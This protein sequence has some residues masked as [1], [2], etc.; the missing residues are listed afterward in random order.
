MALD[1]ILMPLKREL[2]SNQVDRLIPILRGRAEPLIGLAEVMSSAQAEKTINQ[3][4]AGLKGEQDSWRRADLTRPFKALAPRLDD[5]ALLRLAEPMEDYSSDFAGDILN[6]IPQE[7]AYLWLDRVIDKIL[8]T[9]NE[10]R[11]NWM[12]PRVKPLAVR[13]TPERAGK[14][15]EELWKVFIDDQDNSRCAHEAA[16]IEAL[17]PRLTDEMAASL[18]KRVVVVMK[19]PAGFHPLLIRILTPLLGRC[20]AGTVQEAAAGVMA[21]FEKAPGYHA[22]AGLMQRDFLLGLHLTPDQMLRVITPLITE[23][24]N[25]EAP[26]PDIYNGPV[27]CLARMT[28]QLTPDQVERVGNRL[29]FFYTQRP[30][31]LLG[32][33]ALN[34]LATNLPLSPSQAQRLVD[35]VLPEVLRGHTPW[36]DTWYACLAACAR[37]L[38]PEQIEDACTNLISTMERSRESVWTPHHARAFVIFA[39]FAPPDPARRLAERLLQIRAQPNDHPTLGALADASR[40]QAVHSDWALPSVFVDYQE[41]GKQLYRLE[42]WSRCLTALLARMNEADARTIADQLAARCVEQG[43][44]WP[45]PFEEQTARALRYASRPALIRI[46]QTPFAVGGLRHI[47]LRAWELKTGESPA[48]DYWRFMSSV[49]LTNTF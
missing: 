2:G 47:A 1:T 14:L 34:L 36:N 35:I 49:T 21:R 42:S 43:R 22:V 9:P 24:E 17:A 11:R 3:I 18:G 40:S 5:E 27:T 13:L 45:F 28:D 20:D 6:R 32:T 48:N 46:L 15:T 4:L 33:Y 16:C 37:R 19:G 12:I 38:N 41:S 44:T 39:E 29:V 30:S 26:D 10:A 31:G 8:H 25:Y 23:I 7:Q